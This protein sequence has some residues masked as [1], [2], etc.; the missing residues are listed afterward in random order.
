MYTS[1]DGLHDSALS[2]LTHNTAA[3]DIR[4][5]LVPAPLGG[6]TNSSEDTF[7]ASDVPMAANLTSNGSVKDV[8]NFKLNLKRLVRRIRRLGSMTSESDPSQTNG[9]NA[10]SKR[11]THAVRSSL[12]EC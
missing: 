3:R 10:I 9:V 2:A 11:H 1:V 5:L 7:S 12:S 8:H 6:N 4:R